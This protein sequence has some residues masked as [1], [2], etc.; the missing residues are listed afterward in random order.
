MYYF[1]L[2]TKGVNQCDIT[3]MSVSLQEK[4]NIKI[5]ALDTLLNKLGKIKKPI[6]LDSHIHW[7]KS[8]EASL[9]KDYNQLFNFKLKQNNFNDN[10]PILY[11]NIII[12]KNKSKYNNI[13]SFFPEK[14]LLPAKYYNNALSTSYLNEISLYRPKSSSIL[15]SD[16]LESHPQLPVYLSSNS[17]GILFL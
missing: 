10:L 5:N 3:Q 1:F 4:G 15:Y 2:K 17:N 11:Q 8:Y 7:E 14:L 13:N 6:E 9:N 12:P 16:I